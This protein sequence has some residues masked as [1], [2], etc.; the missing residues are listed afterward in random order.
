[1]AT[2]GEVQ[3]LEM[4][5]RLLGVLSVLNISTGHSEDYMRVGRKM[6]F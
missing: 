4:G 5:K 1:M 2:G 6:Y 3:D